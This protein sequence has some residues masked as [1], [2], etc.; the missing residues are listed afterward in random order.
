MSHVVASVDQMERSVFITSLCVSHGMR[1]LV[2][3]V[4]P[5]TVG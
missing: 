2:Q 5:M 1:F 3:T 4:N